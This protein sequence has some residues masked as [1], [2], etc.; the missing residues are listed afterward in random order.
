MASWGEEYLWWEEE[1]ASRWVVGYSG[2]HAAGEWSGAAGDAYGVDGL[3]GGGS[4][5]ARSLTFWN[6]PSTLLFPTWPFDRFTLRT[7]GK[8]W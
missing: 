1:T 7:P 2:Q 5:S 6:V 8:D 4:A 3:V